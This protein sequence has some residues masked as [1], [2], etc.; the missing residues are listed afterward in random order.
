M[1][2]ALSINIALAIGV[3]NS[4]ILLCV[5]VGM[6]MVHTRMVKTNTDLVRWIMSIDPHGWNHFVA[7]GSPAQ[8]NPMPHSVHWETSTPTERGAGEVW[9]G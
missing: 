8:R 2:D 9:S 1:V 7:H 5:I 4:I 3:I 6:N